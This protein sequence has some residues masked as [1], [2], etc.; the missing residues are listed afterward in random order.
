MKIDKDKIKYLIKKKS[1]KQKDVA[2]ELGVGQQDFNNWMF[3]GIFPHYDKLEKLADILEVNVDSLQ[4][5][6]VLMDPVVQYGRNATLKIEH[7]I[8][9]YEPSAT[10]ELRHFKSEKNSPPPKDYMHVPGVRA[11][12]FYPYFGSG[13]ESISNGDLV[14]L[15]KVKDF[16]IL[17]YNKPYA[18]CT[19]EQILWRFINATD[20]KNQ[21]ALFDSKARVSPQIIKDVAVEALFE[22]VAIIKR[23]IQ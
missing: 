23:T 22:I 2:A 20:K 1:M 7:F 5:D 3:R 9:Y 4:N 16:S 6:N 14:A 17:D 21:L 13:F 18:I 12:L 15:R 10:F 8:P 19:S 11:N